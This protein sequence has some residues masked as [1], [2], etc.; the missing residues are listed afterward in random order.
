M[1]APDGYR[2]L[3]TVIA[4]MRAAPGKRQELKAAPGTVTEPAGQED[5]H[6]NHDLAPGRGGPR[7]L[8][9]LRELGLGR[10]ARRAPRRT[11]STS[12]PRSAT[13]STRA[14][15]T[16]RQAPPPARPDAAPPAYPA[17]SRSPSAK[18]AAC[19]PWHWN[20]RNHPAMPHAG[21]N[22]DAATKHDHAGS[23][24]AHG[25]P[26]TTAWSAKLAIECCRRQHSPATATTIHAGRVTARKGA[27]CGTVDCF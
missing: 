2:E 12:P 8:H 4:F 26:V 14:A 17:L 24:R 7:L 20:G 27:V 6:V 5:G 18:S 16:R 3:R 22:G 10:K 1:P 21:S 15:D 13:S 23:T 25:W 9:L 19:S 11:S